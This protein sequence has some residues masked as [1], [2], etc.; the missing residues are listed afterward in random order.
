VRASEREKASI[1]HRFVAD[2]IPYV[3]DPAGFERIMSPSEFAMR[4]IKGVPVR[5][6]CDDSSTLLAA[7]AQS[8]GIP[9]TVAFLDTNGDGQTDHA[10]AVL[11]I[12]SQPVYAE[13]TLRGAELGW[14]PDGVVQS[15]VMI[16]SPVAA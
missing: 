4:I 2:D 1:L 12:D 13:T 10:M 15:T 6:D 3:D 9:A 14:K 8:V 11:M 7:M 16:P 5:G